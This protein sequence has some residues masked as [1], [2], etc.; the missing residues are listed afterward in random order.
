MRATVKEIT[1]LFSRWLKQQ[2]F[3]PADQVVAILKYNLR[4]AK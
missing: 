1:K 3:R 2:I 4:K